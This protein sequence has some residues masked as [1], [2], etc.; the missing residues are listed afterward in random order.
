MY[1]YHWESL[2]QISI[3]L[4]GTFVCNLRSAVAVSRAKVHVVKAFGWLGGLLSLPAEGLASWRGTKDMHGTFD[5][6]SVVNFSEPYMV[7]PGP[8]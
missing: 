4:H 5:R 6:I 1:Y 8:T 2:F 7:T 3:S